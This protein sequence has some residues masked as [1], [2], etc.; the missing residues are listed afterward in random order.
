MSLPTRRIGDLTVSSI[1]L[2]CMPLSNPA[3]L[4]ERERAIATVHRALDLGITLL[5]TS[6]IYAP[7][8]DAVG[9][10]EALAAEAV[11]TYSCLLYT[12]DAADE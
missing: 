11:R 10:N 7:A 9:H 1:G 12:S 5:D 3:M 4:P 6:N 8:W 2:G